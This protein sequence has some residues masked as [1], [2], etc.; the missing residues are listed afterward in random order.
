MPYLGQINNNLHE[1]EST[2]E[3]GL[4]LGTG[5]N[6]ADYSS[7]VIVGVIIV[8]ICPHDVK[9]WGRPI[10]PSPVSPIPNS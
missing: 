6:I 1:H 8:I 5:A 7:C 10:L 2:K 3:R 4:N 9:E